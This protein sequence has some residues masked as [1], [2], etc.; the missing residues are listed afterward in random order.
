MRIGAASIDALRQGEALAGYFA[1]AGSDQAVPGFLSWSFA[2]GAMLELIGDTGQWPRIGFP[3]FVVHGR[4][5]DGGDLSVLGAWV[6]RQTPTDDATAVS[7]SM[8]ALG[9]HIDPDM[10]WPRVVYSTANLSEWCRDTGLSSSLPAPRTRP[11]HFRVDWRPPARRQVDIP[12]ARLTFYGTRDTSVGYSADWH[13]ATFWEVAARPDA[14]ITP[15]EAWRDVAIPLLSFMSFASDR[16]D[17]VV[18]E[19][20]V[21]PDRRSRFE[22]WR[23][24]QTIRP[25]EWRAVDGYLF[26]ADELADYDGAVQAWWALEQQLRPALGMFAEHIREDFSYSPA[27]FLTLYTAIETYARVRHGRNDFRILREYA[28]VPASVIGCD[29]HALA[30][31]GA[32]R[33]YFAHLGAAPSG[34]TIAEIEAN[35]LLSTRRASALMQAC[36]LR[37]LGFSPVESEQILRRHYSNWPLS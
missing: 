37:E 21:D 29:N 18:Q 9:D 6:K 36:L 5:R 10:R 35:V 25:R 17:G 34:P 15:D 4:L 2:D 8:L 24:G 7:A 27:R 30:L 32:S 26:H 13:I 28:G 14:P 11:N 3:P 31:I 23:L 22:V 20:F 19:I 16:P 1:P 33:R 12:G